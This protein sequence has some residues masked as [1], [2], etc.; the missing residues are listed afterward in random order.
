MSFSPLRE[1]N[2]ALDAN[3]TRHNGGGGGGLTVSDEEEED[4]VFHIPSKPSLD[5]LRKWRVS[6]VMILDN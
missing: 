6:F 4:D 3:L 5:M 2:A 1:A